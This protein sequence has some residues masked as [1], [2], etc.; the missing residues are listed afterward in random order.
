MCD[1]IST[2]TGTT[3]PTFAWTTLN[4]VNYKWEQ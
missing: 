1:L 2:T 3:D 4:F